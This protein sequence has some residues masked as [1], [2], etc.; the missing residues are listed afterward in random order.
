MST[1]HTPGPWAVVYGYDGSIEVCSARPVRINL[2]TAG[3]VVVADI[4]KHEDAEHFSAEAN[5]RLIAAAP[6]LLC[7]AKEVLELIDGFSY[8]VRTLDQVQSIEARLRAVVVKATGSA[9]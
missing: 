7:C 1:Q 4:C 2:T 3:S 5:A 8:D 6:E 9:A